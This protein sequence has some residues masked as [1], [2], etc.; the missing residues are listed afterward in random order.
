MGLIWSEGKKSFLVKNQVSSFN[1]PYPIIPFNIWWGFPNFNQG[2]AIWGTNF[3]PSQ[4]FFFPPFYKVPSLIRPF[5]HGAKELGKGP[6]LQRGKFQFY[7]S[8]SVS[9]E[10]PFWGYL[11]GLRGSRA[12]SRGWGTPWG[13]P[14]LVWAPLF[15]VFPWPLKERWSL[16]GVF[17]RPCGGHLGWKPLTHS[18]VKEPALQ[19]GIGD[20]FFSR[21]PRGGG[22]LLSLSKGERNPAF[23]F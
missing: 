1:F 5:L 14:F 23:F 9:F 15:W 21:Y 22:I 4:I 16:W 12:N 11:P 19:K 17:K 18:G 13:F 3:E 7:R 8:L 6:L 20:L 10:T 2:Q